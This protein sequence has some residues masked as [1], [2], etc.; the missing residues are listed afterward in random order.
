MPSS[1][2]TSAGFCPSTSVCH[3][4]SC[5]RSGSDA[6]ARAAA[7]LSNPSTAV[8]R[9]GTPGSNGVEVVG[10]VQPGAG[11]DLVDVQAAYGGQQVGAERE[12]GAAAALEHRQHLRERLGDQVVGV[13]G[14]HELAGQPPGGVDVAAEQLAVGVDVAP[15]DGRDQLGVPG[16]VEVAGAWCSHPFNER[17]RQKDHANRVMDPRHAP[18]S[19]GVRRTREES[20]VGFFATRARAAAPADP[21]ARAELSADLL[22]AL[23]PR[24]EAVGEALASGMGSVDACAVA[25]REL[26]LD[27]VSLDEALDGLLATSSLVRGTEPDYGDARALAEAWSESTLEYLHR[28]TCEDPLTGLASLA[29]LQSRVSELYR[30]QLRDRPAPR[31]SHALV[32]VEVAHPRQARPIDTEPFACRP[33]HRPVRRDR[34]HRLPRPRDP[35][36]PRPAPDRGRHRARRAAGPAGRAAAPDAVAGSRAA[37]GSGSR[38]CRATQHR[39]R[40]PAGRARPPAE[41]RRAVRRRG[42]RRLTPCA[43]ATPRAG[44][45]RT[46][47]RSSRS[48][49]I[50]VPAPLERRLQRRA[51]QRGVRRRRAAA[52]EGVRGAARSASCGCSPGA[53]CRPG[54]RT[55]R[56]ATG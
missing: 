36:P 7:A 29:H 13:A 27:G 25:G 46:S 26:A 37:P 45:P 55:P 43:V 31:Q 21:E 17:K 48:S 38:G 35:G 19:S 14:G 24:F 28:L 3:S 9:N 40:R 53:W 10:G 54:R 18:V 2:A 22:V 42:S 51:H 5:Q 44:A 49:E 11:P 6:K 52:V 47:S 8:S 34:P 33:A 12:V 1:G 50:R 4:T 20:A 16:L 56:S 41:H 32:V 39:R 30:G 23:P 15:A